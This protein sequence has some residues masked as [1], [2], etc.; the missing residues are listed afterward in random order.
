MTPTLPHGTL[1]K[2]R[3]RLAELSKTENHHSSEPIELRQSVPSAESCSSKTQRCIGRPKRRGQR[4][5]PDG[6]VEFKLQWCGE[7]SVAVLNGVT[8]AAAGSSR[9]AGAVRRV[10]NPW[11]GGPERALL[12]RERGAKRS[13]RRAALGLPARRAHV[14]FTRRASR[15]ARRG[16]APKS[17]SAC[18]GA[19]AGWMGSMR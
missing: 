6:E 10:A 18:G 14:C 2:H 7:R 1:V 3:N 5:S 9:R 8:P 17:S 15:R 12:A 19:L 16:Q 4:R 13:R 11:R